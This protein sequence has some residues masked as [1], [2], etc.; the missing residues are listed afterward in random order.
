MRFSE[1]IGQ[2]DIK[3]RLINSVK[4]NRVSHA[5]LFLGPDGCG[6]LALAIAY[7]QYISCTDKQENDSCGT[8]SSCIK[9]EKLIHPDLHFIYPISGSKDISKIFLKQWRE[10]LIGK[11]YYV[12]INE[13]YEYIG[14]ENKQG[15]I[16][17]NDC[18]DIIKTFSLRSYE[19]EYKIMI[20]WMIEKL[21]HS[22]APKLLKIFEEPPEKTL[23]IML[24]ENS[25]LVLPTILS[26]TQMIKIPAISNKSL[27]EAL[28][29][30][31]SLSAKKAHEIIKLSGGNY[32]VALGLLSSEEDI[33]LPVFREWMLNCYYRKFTE[34]I[35]WLD[36]FGKLGREKQ[37]SFFLFSLDIVRSCVLISYGQKQLV[38]V[39]EGEEMEF[40]VKISNFIHS[41]NASVFT[42][43]LEKAIHHIERNANAK[44]LMLDLSIKISELIRIPVQT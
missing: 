32:S 18:H 22:A 3:K 17:A 1:I 33:Y 9:Y 40:I 29:S 21:Y 36:V 15:I 20:I 5:Q 25:D 2:E 35:K 7:A 26:R 23:F 16:N 42:Q 27:V 43:E 38:M 8:C 13:W 12:S 14:L 11:N 41:G 31:H 24:S 34:I 37:K 6:K 28:V 30:K 39:E 19:S 44:I 4:E 10:F